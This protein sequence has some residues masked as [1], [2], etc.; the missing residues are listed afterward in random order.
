M[1][2]KLLQWRRSRS[3]SNLNKKKKNRSKEDLLEYRGPIQT[4]Q[5][6]IEQHVG[7]H[8]D[9]QFVRGAP[10]RLSGGRARSQR[11][12]QKDPLRRHSMADP[13]RDGARDPWAQ[14][15]LYVREPWQQQQQQQHYQ[16]PWQASSSTQN[17]Y[18]QQ[19]QGYQQ[20]VYSTQPK[21]V[22]LP[23][24]NT[25]TD[26]MTAVQ[27]YHTQRSTRIPAPPAV[28]GQPRQGTHDSLGNAAPRM[29]SSVASSQIVSCSPSH[30]QHSTSGFSSGPASTKHSL[31]SVRTEARSI[32]PN[33]PVVDVVRPEPEPLLQ[34]RSL[35]FRLPKQDRTSS[36]LRRA[37]SLRHR[38]DLAQSEENVRSA[39][40]ARLRELQPTRGSSKSAE[41]LRSRSGSVYG[42]ESTENMLDIAVDHLSSMSELNKA[43]R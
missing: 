5:P 6:H 32:E 2:E 26:F 30:T 29:R 24:E 42:T 9:P 8:D 10:A 21:Q 43:N 40:P 27:Q 14:T 37:N 20:H 23:M 35:S 34:R 3:T 12:S 33:D 28:S 25:R 16:R 4:A 15:E 11:S 19:Q 31:E 41:M 7:F 39:S 17:G 18:Y 36:S 38:K 22:L 1:F 13:S